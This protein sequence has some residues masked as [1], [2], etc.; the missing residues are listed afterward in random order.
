MLIWYLFDH[1]DH[2]WKYTMTDVIKA[3]SSEYLKIL[4]NSKRTIRSNDPND[5]NDPNNDE[6]I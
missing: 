3:S 6:L 1:Y 4:I 5:P 2:E